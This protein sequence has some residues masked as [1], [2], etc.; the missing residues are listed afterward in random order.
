M[1]CD[2]DHDDGDCPYCGGEGVTFECFDGFCEDCDIGCDD[3]TQPCS[4][5]GIKT[6]PLP[7]DLAVVLAAALRK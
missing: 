3:C 1:S 5:C 6:R 4:H 2:P 7:P